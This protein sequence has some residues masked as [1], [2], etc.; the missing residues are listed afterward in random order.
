MSCEGRAAI[1]VMGIFLL[2]SVQACECALLSVV[3]LTSV[4]VC[5]LYMM[6][7]RG[8]EALPVVPAGCVAAIGGLGAAILKSATLASSPACRPLA[9]MLFQVGSAV[10]LT[11]TKVRAWILF[12]GVFWPLVRS[13]HCRPGRC[14]PQVYRT[15]VFARAARFHP[16]CS[17]KEGLHSDGNTVMAW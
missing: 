5:G 17:S 8:L 7:G 11:K 10:V 9:P 4:Q 14:H 3:H 13:R 12:S 1:T 15:G 2:Y 6:M 16:C